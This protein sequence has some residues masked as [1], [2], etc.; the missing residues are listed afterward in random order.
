[1]AVGVKFAREYEDIMADLTAALEELPGSYTLLDMEEQEWAELALDEQRECMRTLA[2]DVFYGLGSDP[3]LEVGEG[4]LN[5]DAV[6]H[7]LTLTYPG[8]VTRIIRLI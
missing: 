1:M 2:D 6:K 4:A 5:H 3:V 8:G 7:V